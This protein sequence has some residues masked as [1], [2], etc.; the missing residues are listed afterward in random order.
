MTYA[1][2]DLLSLDT[3]GRCICDVSTTNNQGI[4]LHPAKL[5]SLTGVRICEVELQACGTCPSAYRRY[6]RPDGR[7]AGIFNL[8]NRLLFT[9]GLLDD[10]TASF[11]SSETPFAAWVNVVQRRYMRYGSPEPFVPDA[12][13]MAAWFGYSNLLDMENDMIC[14]ACGP[15]PDNVIW[16]GV[17]LAFHRKLL[18]SL[19]PPTTMHENSMVKQSRRV[20]HILIKSSDVRRSIRKIIELDRVASN[21]NSEPSLGMLVERLE[22]LQTTVSA[23]TLNLENTLTAAM[24]LKQWQAMEIR[25]K[26]M[27]QLFEQVCVLHKHW[28]TN[29]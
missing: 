4:A 22:L 15:T 10:Y 29:S 23:L 28:I 27:V 1:G 9:H 14:P 6:V 16:D 17:S 3:N 7:N 21:S 24:V 8:N 2:I 20:P 19:Q 12:V 25:A 13:F 11:T 26:E 18:P 5:Y